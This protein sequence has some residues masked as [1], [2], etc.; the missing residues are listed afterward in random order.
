MDEAKR[1]L[2][3]SWLTIAFQ[4]LRSA[5]ALPAQWPPLLATAAYHCQQTAEKSLKGLLVYH[6]E[7]PP[8]LHL[9][10]SLI[11]SASRFDARIAL[12]LDAADKLTPLATEYR[13]PGALRTLT[14]AEY[15]QAYQDAEELY[16]YIL[17]VLPV[18]VR[19]K[20]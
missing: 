16:R 20:E 4:D 19:P 5:S 6:D 2:V 1:D 14:Q 17:S 9:L 3:Q 11:V 10:D 7:T 8:K 18:N 15:E 12:F 13:Y